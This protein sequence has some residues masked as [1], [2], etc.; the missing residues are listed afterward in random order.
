MAEQQQ[1]KSIFGGSLFLK[2][3]VLIAIVLIV[4]TL[5]S[6]FKNIGDLILNILKFGLGLVI[7]ILVWKG[8]ESFFKPTPFSP[9]ESFR[10]KIIRASKMRKPFNVKRLFIRGE[11]MLVY[12]KWYDIK[13]I[14]FLPYI[15]AKQKT[16]DEGKPIYIPKIGTNGKP[17]K[18]EA[19]KIIM[20][21]QYNLT[22]EHD[23]EWVFVGETG[24]FLNKKTEIV[25]AHYSLCSSIG[26][27][28]Y[29]KTPNLVPIGDYS[30]PT[31]Q[32]QDDIIH[33]ISQHKTEALIE[34][35]EH[36]LDLLANVTQ[37]SL[38]SD[39]TFQK[40]MLAQSEALGQRN[41]GFLARGA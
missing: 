28:I 31:Q 27:S 16:D 13:G 22:T 2:I 24:W 19:K 17:V 26:E 14:L 38:G 35:Y 18:D 41:A 4:W 32:W 1:P 8:I 39:P 30:Y 36:F 10:N 40:I 6:S 20:I 7:L 3:I 37:M 25:R 11:D 23:G 33:V 9:T 12:S 29:I 34:T 5:I 15:S 21:P